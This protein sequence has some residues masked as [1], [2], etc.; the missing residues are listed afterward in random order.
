MLIR[1]AEL[2]GRGETDVRL[3]AGRIAE[4]GANLSR[5]RGEPELEAGGGALLPGLHDHHIHLFALAAAAGSIDC[6]PAAVRNAEGLRAAL[7]RAATT[8]SGWLRGVAYHECVAG[9]LDRARL[10]AWVPRRPLRIQHRSGA[11]W[12]L[13]SAA[14]A[15]L[16]AERDP[17]PAGLERDASGRPTGRLYRGDDWLRA[18][19]GDAPPGLGAVGA[20]LAALGITGITDAGAGNGAEAMAEL[21]AAVGSGALPQRL[22]VMGT[23]ELPAPPA[24]LRARVARGAVK[25]LLDEARLPEL[26]RLVETLREAHA[27]GRAAA[28]HCATRTEV[29]FAL[30]ALRAAGAH[31][32]DRLEHAS[33]APPEAVAEAA[34]LGL[35]V[36]SQPHFLAERGEQYAADVAPEDLPWLYRGRAWLDA[37][38]PLAA[39]SDAPYGSPDPWASMRAAVERRSGAGRP[40][41]PDEALVPEQALALFTAPADDPGGPPRKIEPG[42]PAELCLLD[43]PWR[44]A[45]LRLRAEDV[46]ASFCAGR[47]VH[48]R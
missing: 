33:V 41:A 18:R 2:P 3:R 47:P 1:R 16:G 25:L 23:P 24:S 48:R 36:V 39:G 43:R 34:A 29:L 4:I 21:C 9:D 31:R 42:A 30:A 15:A 20:R 14:L 28:L 35:R 7:A 46:A 19:G 6:G 44:E 26:D 5:A 32:G 22:R 37:G 11:L 10:D 45:R 8:G 13:N 12:V 17:A 38:V 40:L 27:A